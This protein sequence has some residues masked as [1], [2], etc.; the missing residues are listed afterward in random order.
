M[1]EKPSLIIEV[2]ELSGEVVY[3]RPRLSDKCDL[4]GPKDE[5]ME[6][7]ADFLAQQDYGER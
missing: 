1:A 3:M 7:M 4:L 5:V 2:D 6:T